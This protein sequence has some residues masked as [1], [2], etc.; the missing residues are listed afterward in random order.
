MSRVCSLIKAKLLLQMVIQSNVVVIKDVLDNSG[1]QKKI[2]L[3]LSSSNAL[4]NNVKTQR[5]S[6]IYQEVW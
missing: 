3:I 2:F 6:E 1:T 4:T 5:W